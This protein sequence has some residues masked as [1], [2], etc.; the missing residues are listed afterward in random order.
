MPS[1]T[2]K[3]CN[4]PSNR[5]AISTKFVFERKLGFGGKVKRYKA[6]L[7][8]H[9]NLQKSGVVF[10]ETYASVVAWVVALTSI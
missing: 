6:R 5:T 3:L 2:M 7:V 10:D 4:L 1:G 9:G 8:V